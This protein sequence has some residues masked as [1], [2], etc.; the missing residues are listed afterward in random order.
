[1]GQGKAERGLVDTFFRN[2]HPLVQDDE[3]GEILL[4]GFDALTEH[5][6][7]VHLRREERGDGPDALQPFPGH[8]GRA[9]GRIFALDHLDP[10][11]FPLEEIAGL[12]DG[13][14]VRPD[15]PD[16]LRA[17]S[18]QGEEVLLDAQVDFPFNLPGMVPEQFKISH[19]TAG[20]SIL[21]GHHRRIGPAFLQ[22]TVQSVEG[23][24]GDDINGRR[25][26]SGRSLPGL[27]E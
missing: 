4:I 22:G 12:V 24:A 16:I 3:T 10:G 21:H 19:Q 23:V 18:R 1:M 26:R 20:N 13:H 5:V 14:I 9:L 2:V 25:L 7:S 15:L 6:K 27:I 8:L 17:L 11:T